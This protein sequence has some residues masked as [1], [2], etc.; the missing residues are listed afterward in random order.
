MCLQ[1]G[2]RSAWYVFHIKIADHKNSVHSVMYENMKNFCFCVSLFAP[3][4]CCVCACEHA[5]VF[6]VSLLRVC[7]RVY[8]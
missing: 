3:S 2:L 1:K 6:V 5:R 7:I 8:M 4:L